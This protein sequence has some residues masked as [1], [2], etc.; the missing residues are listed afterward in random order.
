M[1]R[2]SRTYK[3]LGIDLHEHIS[4]VILRHRSREHA[5]SAY[6]N[7]TRQA[8]R[9]FEAHGLMPPSQKLHSTLKKLHASERDSH[10][11]T[12]AHLGT[13][14]QAHSR[15]DQGHDFDAVMLSPGIYRMH[16]SGDTFLPHVDT[17]H[18]ADWANRCTAQQTNGTTSAKP[19]KRGPRQGPSSAFPEMYRFEHQFSALL[20]MQPPEN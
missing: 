3:T 9:V 16:R 18:S 14:H 12:S 6:V 4:Q 10:P 15:H 17:L 7:A 1:R 2:R 20:M 11:S 5:L 13:E 19:A 8:T